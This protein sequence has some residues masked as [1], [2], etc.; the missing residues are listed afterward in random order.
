MVLSSILV[1]S[2]PQIYLF[3]SHYLF[4]CVKFYNVSSFVCLFASFH[5][6]SYFPNENMLHFWQPSR[7]K[8]ISSLLQ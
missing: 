7:K 2:I 1:K 3:T 8:M 5:K 6:I 4:I